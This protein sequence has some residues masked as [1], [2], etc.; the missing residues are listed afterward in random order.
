MRTLSL[1]EDEIKRRKKIFHLFLTKVRNRQCAAGLHKW[2][3]FILSLRH[4]ERTQRKAAARWKHALVHRSFST[5]HDSVLTLVRNRNL[6][7]RALKRLQHRCL[8]RCLEQWL[9]LV[10]DR[11]S[12]RHRML[13]CLARWR[14]VLIDGGF[15]K[16]VATT[17]RQARS[18][19][20]LELDEAQRLTVRQKEHYEEAKRHAQLKICVVYY[21]IRW[22]RASLRKW[23]EGTSRTKKVAQMKRRAAHTFRNVHLARSFSSWR[24]N[25]IHEIRRRQSLQRLELSVGLRRQHD[26]MVRSIINRMRHRLVH[27][28]F[29]SWR[30]SQLTTKRARAFV[31]RARRGTEARCLTKWRAQVTSEMEERSARR[32]HMQ[33]ILF[34]MTRSLVSRGWRAWLRCLEIQRSDFRQREERERERERRVRRAIAS[35]RRTNIVLAFRRWYVVG[36]GSMCLFVFFF[37]FSPL[38]A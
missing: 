5:W 7:A 33:I 29:S 23:R 6:I 37:L 18:R 22:L 25:T 1:T 3:D 24:T 11:C 4:E 10:D 27:Q 26:R 34:K 20:K 21:R 15:R 8:T 2:C 17:A 31:L 28:C 36:S 38:V 35:M 9:A 19:Y 30:E 32:R 12:L 16:W 14:Q 13:Q